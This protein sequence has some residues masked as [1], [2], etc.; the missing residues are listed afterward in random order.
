MP[1]FGLGMAPPLRVT[2]RVRIKFTVRVTAR[3]RVSP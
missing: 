3:V 2:V 1:G